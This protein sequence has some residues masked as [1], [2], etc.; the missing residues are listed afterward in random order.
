[1]NDDPNSNSTDQNEETIERPDAIE[2]GMPA[3]EEADK[4][5]EDDPAADE[6]TTEDEL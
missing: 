2:T 3:T 6:A 4:G 1:M 5:W